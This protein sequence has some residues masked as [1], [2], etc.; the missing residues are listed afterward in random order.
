MRLFV[1]VELDAEVLD[2]IGQLTGELGREVPSVRWARRESLH[3]TLKFLGEVDD[4]RVPALCERL[5]SAVRGAGGPFPMEVEGLGTFGDSL[6]PRVVWAGIQERS[7]ALEALRNAVEGAAVAEGFDPEPRS[8]RP[9]LTLARLKGGAAGLGRALATRAGARLGTS[10]VR[11]VT[12][13]SSRLSPSGAQY[14]AVRR[15]ELTEG[16]GGGSA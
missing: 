12:L 13:M 7:G 5:A 3:L 6:K 15:F 8:F 1:A 9:H 4:G 2:R 16:A 10:V 11:G 14:S